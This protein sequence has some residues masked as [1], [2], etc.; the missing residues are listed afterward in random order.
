MPRYSCTKCSFTTTKKTDYERHLANKKPCGLEPVITKELIEKEVDKKVA[1]KLAEKEIAELLED[2]HEIVDVSQVSNVVLTHTSSRDKILSLVN[3]LHNKMRNNDQLTGTKAHHDII[4]LLFIRFI[5]PYL[6]E[7]L[8]TLMDVKEYTSLDSFE[9]HWLELYNLETL[10]KSTNDDF[11]EHIYKVWDMFSVHNFTKLIFKK[12]STFH[13]KEQ[14][15]VSC[16]RDIYK[17]LKNVDFDNLTSDIKG[18]I[19]EAFINSYAGNGGKEFGQYFTPR[20]MIKSILKL[21]YE[22]GEDEKFNPRTI[23]DPCM[24][25]AGFLTEAYKFIKDTNVNFQP[26][27]IYGNELEPETYMSGLMNILLLT[28]C[29]PN[30]SCRNSFTENSDRKYDLIITNPPFGVKVNYK[31]IIVDCDFK[32][33]SVVLPKKKGVKET[34][35]TKEAESNASLDPSDMYP[36]NI[37]DGS[38]LFLQHC[39]AKLNMGGICAI[40]LPDGQLLTGANKY[41][42]V[43]KYLLENFQLLA[44]LHIPGGAFTHA[45]VKTAVFIFRNNEY[46]TDSVKFYE[47]DK[48]CMNYKL[49][50]EIDIED[51]KAKKYVLNYQYYKKTEQSIQITPDSWEIKKL[52]DV[53][54]LVKGKKH[55]VSDGTDEGKYPLLCSS[56]QDKR[57][58]LDTYE[59]NGPYIVFGTGGAAN[60]HLCEKF[61]IS[62]DMKVFKPIGDL[63]EYVYY[64]LKSNITDINDTYFRGVTIKHITMENLL[65]I[66]IPIPPIDQQKLIVSECDMYMNLKKYTEEFNKQLKLVSTLE[67]NKKVKNIFTG[68]IKTLGEVCEL[69][70]GKHQSSRTITKNNGENRFITLASEEKWQYSDKYDADGE[71]VFVG[72]TSSGSLWPVHYYNGKMAYADLL[73]RMKLQDIII[74]KF[75]YYFMVTS[76]QKDIMD[77]Y[78][79]GAANK[80]LDKDLFN[81]IQI[82]IPPIDQQKLIVEEYEKVENIIRNNQK[83][84]DSIDSKIANTI[85][86]SST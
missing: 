47:C 67:Y 14:T 56:T 30:I 42:S 38:A 35:E 68:E 54:E 76:V 48:E 41:Q 26:M 59:Y 51:I 77:K 74:P 10:L 1:E 50:E 61:N 4:R 84:I 44:V 64:F 39:M 24:G 15:I 11:K 13:C 22:L 69:V 8:A 3:C 85:N 66:E 25:T 78:I 37:N 53:C 20:P 23:Y 43:R 65:S 71:N 31:N 52:S 72:Y 45:G 27:N 55:N 49:L 73:Y 83:I 32:T 63:I 70:K 82:P 12:G 19:Y 21:V 40:V 79:K 7:R 16:L 6:N 86:Q 81:D 36:V 33:P 2:K 5:Q 62:T 29:V 46:Q 18:E 80:S 17:T 57:K 58:Y 34:K 9:P 75:M 28:G 60:V